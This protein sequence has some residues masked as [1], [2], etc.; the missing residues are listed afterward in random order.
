MAVLL[1]RG[2][3]TI[4]AIKDGA[5]GLD[6]TDGISILIE[7][8]LVFDTDDTGKVPTSVLQSKKA[9]VRVMQGGANVSGLVKKLTIDNAAYCS[10]SALAGIGKDIQVQHQLDNMSW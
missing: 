1:A 5:D 6:G 9:V 7:R 3:I 4:A 2:Q 8:P 10:A